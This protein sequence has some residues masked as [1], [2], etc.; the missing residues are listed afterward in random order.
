MRWLCLVFVAGCYTVTTPRM[1]APVYDMPE[2][3]A[4][5]LAAIEC[6]DHAAGCR[7]IREALRSALESSF[8][9][10]GFPLVAEA[11][12]ETAPL[13]LAVVVDHWPRGG[14]SDVDITFVMSVRHGA[15][16]DR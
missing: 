12:A 7:R 8:T 9:L 2:G 6:N 13:Q 11:A 15:E 14:N 3:T 4:I 10:R 16:L 5:G 1:Q